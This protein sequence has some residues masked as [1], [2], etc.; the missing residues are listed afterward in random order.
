MG[1]EYPSDFPEF[2]FTIAFVPTQLHRAKPELGFVS[3][4]MH[5]HMRRFVGFG[6]VKPDAKAFDAQYRRHRIRLRRRQRVRKGNQATLAGEA[7]GKNYSS[8]TNGRKIK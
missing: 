1:C 8:R 4:L 5:M 3:G 2:G 7:G 6:T